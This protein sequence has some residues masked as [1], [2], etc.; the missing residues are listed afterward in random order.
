MPS[1]AFYTLGCKVNFYDT[2]A[3]WQLFKKE[4]YEQVDFETTTADVYVIN[5]CTVTN[6]GDKKSRQIIRRAVRR[7]PDAVIA[8]TGCYAQTSPAEIMAIPGVDLVVGTQ[9]RDKLM[10]FISDI[11]RDRKPVNA[12]RNI[13][14]TREFEE[15]DVPAFADRT[16]AFLKIQEGCNNFCT[17]C[18]IPWSR[19]LSRSRAPESVLSQARQ[20]VAAGY[21]EIVLTGIHTGGYGDDL[22]GYRLANLL[23]DLDKIEGL[24]RIRISSIE[25]SQID[26]EM[27]RVLNGSKKMCRHLHIPLQ[28][29]DD[30]ILKRMRRKYTTEEFAGKIA[31]IKE[32][33]PG[34]AITTD[35]IVGFP[36]E[37]EEQYENGYRFMERIGFSEMHVFPYSKRTGTPASRM[38]EQ[39]D[40]EVKHARVHRLIELSERLQGE[41]SRHWVGEELEVIPERVTKGEDGKVR[42]AGYSDN[43]LSVEFEGDESM[44]RKRCLV[45]VTESGANE[46]RGELIAVLSDV[47]PMA[48][49]A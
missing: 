21:Q 11:Q 24:E 36:G 26:D 45:R 7:N 4:G 43:Y 28:A 15:L 38:D 9:D 16:R 27:I 34:V 1:V 3:M 48:M 47:R 19:G 13:M 32:A 29:G 49:Q 6:T 33:M 10:S 5:T 18:I 31:R 25:A 35:V 42:L 22:E 17:F 2:E 40:E 20:L 12:V 46:N 14:K 39:V 8:V 30:A 37:T 41:Y 44:Y 23:E